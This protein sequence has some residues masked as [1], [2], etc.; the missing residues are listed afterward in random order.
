MTAAVLNAPLAWL[1]SV[2]T[3]RTLNRFVGDF[4]VIDSR[5]AD[6]LVL[7]L[8]NGLQLVGIIF[9]GILVSPYLLFCA[10]PLLAI[11]IAY[12]RLYL[13]GARDTKRL[14]ECLDS[15]SSSHF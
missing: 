5:L 8:Y 14:G 1:D 12:A 10:I 15:L 9:A 11:C 4:C 13:A 6:N 2:P 7:L 3:G